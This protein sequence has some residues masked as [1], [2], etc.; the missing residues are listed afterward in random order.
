M[1]TS[2]QAEL[3]LHGK[4]GDDALKA[5]RLRGK[6]LSSALH[7]LITPTLAL[8]DSGHADQSELEA[9]GNIIA[10]QGPADPLTPG[11]SGGDSPQLDWCGTLRSGRLYR[12][13]APRGQG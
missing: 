5:R 12:V 9:D 8:E 10:L 3:R 11:R 6:E 4:Q 2:E 7:R 13:A 1:T